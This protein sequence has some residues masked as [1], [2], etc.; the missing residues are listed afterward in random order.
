MT[1]VWVVCLFQTELSYIVEHFVLTF[2]W[3]HSV[4]QH[5]C[6]KVLVKRVS[7]DLVL[8]KEVELVTK[9][10]HKFSARR[11]SIAVE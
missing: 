2:T 8:Y 3:Y 1:R 4:C 9:F 5:N 11:D 10:H 6:L 7:A